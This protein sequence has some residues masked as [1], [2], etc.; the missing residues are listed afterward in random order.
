MPHYIISTQLLTLLEK[1]YP[2]TRISFFFYPFLEQD[3]IK[4]LCDGVDE[5]ICLIA[6]VIHDVDH[7]GKNS[8]F[9]C[10]SGSELANLYNDITVLGM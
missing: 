5:A 3:S 7:P 6:A 10:N 4:E 8:A 1:K 2:S 9:L